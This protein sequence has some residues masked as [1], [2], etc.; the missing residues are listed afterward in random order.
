VGIRFSRD[1]C[2]NLESSLRQEWLDS[3]GLG[4]Y[5]SSTILDC[6]TRK[7]HGLLVANL[8]EPSG[9]YVLLSKLEVS[10]RAGDSEFHLSTNKFPG[11]FY[12]TGH[13]YV[14]SFN[15]DTFPVTTYT[16]GDIQFTRSVMMVHGENTVLVKLDLVRANKP[17]IVRAMP[18]LAYRDL[19]GLTRQNMYLRVKT[20][21][22]GNASKIDPYKGMPPLY[23]D[24]SGKMVFFPGPHWHNNFE[25]LKELSRGYDYQEDHSHSAPACTIPPAT[26]QAY[27]TRRLHGGRNSSNTSPAIQK[28]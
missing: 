20:F 23:F 5:A 13:K 19:H 21:P 3:N 15:Y 28:M 24:W 9:K 6:H 22:A 8:R 17:V 14:E 1:Q 27:G 12:P 10:I 16:I 25:Y 7:Y 18:L 26:P 11:V 2:L 4:G